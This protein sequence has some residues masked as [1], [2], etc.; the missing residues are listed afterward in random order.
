MNILL[1]NDDGIDS[2]ITRALFKKLSEN[3]KVT[4]IAPKHDKAASIPPICKITK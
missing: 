3:H 2:N 4:L 1:T